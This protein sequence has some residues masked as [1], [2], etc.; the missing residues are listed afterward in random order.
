MVP[1]MS[2]RTCGRGAL[3]LGALLS[4]VAVAAPARADSIVKHPGD[5]PAYSFEAEPHLVVPL[6]F[7]GV[8]PGFRGTVVLVDNGFISSINNSVGLGFGLDWIFYGNHCHGPSNDHHCDTNSE[9]I[10]PLVMQWNF[11]LHPRWS[12]FGE[13]GVAF[14]VRGGNGHHVD[15]D[16]FTIY[17]GGRYHLSDNFAFTMRLGAPL[18]SENV[19]SI[20]ASMLF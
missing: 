9:A 16:W 5:H 8:G 18:L 17:V 3:A 7:D 12:V 19:F 10:L 2:R 6:A 4:A 13:P 14:H 11:W 20:G 1:D 15:F